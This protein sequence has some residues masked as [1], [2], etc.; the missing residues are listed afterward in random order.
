MEHAYFGVNSFGIMLP[1]YLSTHRALERGFTFLDVMGAAMIVALF[2]SGV[3]Y[4]NS[5]VLNMLRASK[6]TIIASKILQQR[7][8]QMRGSNWSEIT[9]AP[10]LYDIYTTAPDAA[11]GLNSVTE[12]LT[13]SAYPSVS[14]TNIKITRSTA[15]LTTIAT[16]NPDLV[17]GSAVRV[18]ARVTWS[19][20]PGGITRVREMSTVMST[21]GLGR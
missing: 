9:D 8:E 16:D 15:G 11:V 6:E 12:I 20:T 7:M 1:K 19:G 13:V 21:G 2:L 17:D 4:G 18:D 3:F 10:T 14:G 5:R